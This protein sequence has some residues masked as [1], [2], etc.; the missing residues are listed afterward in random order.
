M[1]AS[2]FVHGHRGA[3]AVLPENTLPAFE[4]AIQAGADYL[5]LDLAVTR[6]NVLV[7]SHDPVLPESICTGGAGTRVIREMTVA[8]LKQWDCGSRANLSFPRQKAVPG[9]HVPTLD[10]V[11][12]LADR[13]SFGFNIETKLS[14]KRPELT[15]P[16][17]EF[18]R[19]LY[20]AIH[21]RG[22]ENRVLV[23]SFDFRTLHAMKRI[24]PAI[25][26][27]ALIGRDD[28]RDWAVVAQESGA[29]CIAPEYNLVTPERVQKAHA[30][31]LTVVPWTV[32][33]AAEWDRLVAAGVDGIITDDPAA[34]LAH[35]KSAP[36]PQAAPPQR[37]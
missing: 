15:P 3:R 1:A 21:K 36:P 35:L 5:E 17:E 30:I 24:A 19:L 20:D 12:A 13:G 9:T 8:E 2:V 7:V 26:L 14:A 25:R 16:P 6:D 18:A 22:L 10:E 37:P 34:L 4:H 11:F 33:D 29:G 31:G 28:T 32:N 23:Q 27:N